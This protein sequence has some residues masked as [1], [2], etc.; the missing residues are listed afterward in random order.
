ML[1]VT[2]TDALGF[3]PTFRKAYWRPHTETVSAFAI[4]I[5][6]WIPGIAALE[7]L[8][9]TTWLYPVSIVLLNGSFIAMVV[10][11]RRVPAAR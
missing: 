2:V 10:A 5:V 6:K 4:A 1:L 7:T 8:T 9:P 11:R 3:I